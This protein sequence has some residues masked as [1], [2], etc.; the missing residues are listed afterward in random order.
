MT[1]VPRILELW[2]ENDAG[3]VVVVVGGTIPED[4]ADELRKL[5]V[6]GVFGPGAPT[7]EIVDFLKGAVAA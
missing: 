3:D 4:D 5:G 7:T 2:R 6:A 1:L